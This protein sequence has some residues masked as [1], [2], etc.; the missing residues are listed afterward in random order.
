MLGRLASFWEG[1]FSRAMSVWGMVFLIQLP[2]CQNHGYEV[3][4]TTSVFYIDLPSTPSFLLPLSWF[5]CV[6]FTFGKL[7]AAGLRHGPQD[8]QFELLPRD[9]IG[10]DLDWARPKPCHN[11]Y[12]IYVDFW[13]EK[14]MKLH[15]PPVTAFRQVPRDSMLASQF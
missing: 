4:W 10:V 13:K 15:Y 8:F 14:A 12:I 3:C 2:G 7:G 1:Q 9:S 6:S 5:F 11:G